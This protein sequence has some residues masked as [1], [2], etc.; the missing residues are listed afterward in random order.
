MTRQRK[1]ISVLL[2]L[3]ALV[4]L[5]VPGVC[6]TDLPEAAGVGS[7][8]APGAKFFAARPQATLH[9]SRQYQNASFDDCFC[10]STHVVPGSTILL[11]PSVATQ[12]VTP[13][14]AETDH[15]IACP[16]PPSTYHSCQLRS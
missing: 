1:L 4:D 12:D 6:K 10:C 11:R 13:L 14:V 3:Y 8:S 15:L 7:V 2:L 16:E 9:S 5:A